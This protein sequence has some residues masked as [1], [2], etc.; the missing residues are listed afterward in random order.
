[1]QELRDWQLAGG[2]GMRR[3]K[4]PKTSTRGRQ[5]QK[6]A[7]NQ[8]GPAPK[9]DKTSMEASTSRGEKRKPDDE[10]EA[11]RPKRFKGQV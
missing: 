3:N 4:G 6:D 10:P 1:M 9:E 7:D 11:V 5:T 8:P 2:K